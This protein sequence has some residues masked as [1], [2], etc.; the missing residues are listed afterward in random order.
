[1]CNVR[2]KKKKKWTL[3]RLKFALYS[4]CLF[5][6]TYA[7]VILLQNTKQPDPSVW[8]NFVCY[9]YIFAAW[10]LE[11]H[12]LDRRF[13]KTWVIMG[14]YEASTGADAHRST[15]QNFNMETNETLE[16]DQTLSLGEDLQT[17]IPDGTRLL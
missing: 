13:H 11:V 8:V 10:F 6:S 5:L 2:I 3:T 12:Y 7:I 15:S 1:M 14:E 9:R 16:E 4:A 17:N